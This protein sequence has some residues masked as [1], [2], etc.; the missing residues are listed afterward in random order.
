MSALRMASSAAGSAA[1]CSGSMRTWAMRQFWARL[2]AE[3]LDSPFTE[4]PFS[5]CATTF[6][7]SLV[8]GSTCPVMARTSLIRATAWSK[9][10][11]MPFSAARNRFPKLCPARLPSWNR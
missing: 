1:G 5:N 10:G 4:V 11:E 3:I 6:T 8:T 9:E 2:K 7:F